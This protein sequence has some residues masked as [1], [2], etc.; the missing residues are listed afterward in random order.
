MCEAGV[1][2]SCSGTSGMRVQIFLR[3]RDAGVVV[4][5]GGAVDMEACFTETIGAIV[6]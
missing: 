2:L 1:P 4:E 5:V 3:G 6:E